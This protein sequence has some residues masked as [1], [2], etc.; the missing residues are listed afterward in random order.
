MEGDVALQRAKVVGLSLPWVPEAW[1][2]VGCLEWQRFWWHQVW[3]EKQSCRRKPVRL[4]A[5]CVGQ[6]S[7][8]LCPS[9]HPSTEVCARA[10]TTSTGP[11]LRV[12]ESSP[13]T[14]F[15]VS[16]SFFELGTTEV[17]SICTHP[18]FPLEKL[19]TCSA[20]PRAAKGH[21]SALTWGI[22]SFALTWLHPPPVQ[23]WLAP[24]D[25]CGS[26]EGLVL[27]TC[28]RLRGRVGAVP[29]DSTSSFH[30]IV[31]SMSQGFLVEIRAV[32]K[33]RR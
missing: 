17:S 7:L 5:G 10:R 12:I 30:C 23:G 3:S 27:V 2:C 24:A 22:V 14:C 29:P 32:F 13:F 16:V 8:P 4:L 26:D 28:L 1:A 25:E 9:A 15:F 6:H 21:T 33:I 31:L 19:S 18:K 11:G 20:E